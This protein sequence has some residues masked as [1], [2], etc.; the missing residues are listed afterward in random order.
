MI[1][2]AIDAASKWVLSKGL[3]DRAAK[4]AALWFHNE[5]CLRFGYPKQLTCDREG[6]FVGLFNTAMLDYMGIRTRQT[7][8]YNPM[9]NGQAENAHRTYLVALR[10]LSD[11][12]EPDWSDHLAHADFA[13]NTHRPRTTGVAPFVLMFGRRPYTPVSILAGVFEPRVSGTDEVTLYA[14]YRDAQKVRELAANLEGRARGAAMPE[15]LEEERQDALHVGDLVLVSFDANKLEELHQGPYRVVKLLGD[16]QGRSAL[17]ENVHDPRDRIWRNRRLMR[18]YRG[19]PEAPGKRREWEVDAILAERGAPPED[20]YLVSFTGF[21]SEHNL[22]VSRDNLQA[23][24]LLADWKKQPAHVRK[25]LGAEALIG[26]DVAI[27]GT[28]TPSTEERVQVE[29]V[30]DYRETRQGERYFVAP[31]G[32]GPRGYRWVSAM[33]IANPEI[34]RKTAVSAASGVDAHVM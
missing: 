33:E 9:S 34:L 3:P 8:P 19:D 14:W 31:I 26:R 23:P 22:W 6:A 24:E 13:L 11:P 27:G 1:I 29:R 18:R 4:P 7:S 28:L 2:Q 21:S 12:D 30:L 15:D 32:S 10:A 5:W 17:L 25:R 16:A 20:E